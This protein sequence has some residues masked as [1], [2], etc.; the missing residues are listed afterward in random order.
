MLFFGI[1]FLLYRSFSINRGDGTEEI[2]YK[3]SLKIRENTKVRDVTKD[4]KNPA[5]IYC[6]VNV[7]QFSSYC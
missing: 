4:E 7:I 3:Y 5:N 6:F 1:A 2:V